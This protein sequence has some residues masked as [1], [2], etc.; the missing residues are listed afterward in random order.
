MSPEWNILDRTHKLVSAMAA[1]RQFV[2]APGEIVRSVVPAAV[3][4]VRV[5]EGGQQLRTQAGLRNLILPGILI[6]PLPVE[7]QL[8]AGLNCADDEAHRL[9]IQIVDTASFSGGNSG[10]IRSY[11]DWIDLIRTELLTIP[12]PYLQDA[13]VEDYDPFVVHILKR[14]PSETQ[15]LVRHEQQVAMLNFQ[16]MVRHQR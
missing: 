6:S 14:L 8:Y 15:S 5:V 9:T 3:Q 13:D 7:T 11:L 16:V 10:K 12:N 1:G 2:A 4:I